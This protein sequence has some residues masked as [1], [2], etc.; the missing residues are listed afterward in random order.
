MV[1]INFNDFRRDFAGAMKPLEE[2]YGV[3]INL[4]RISCSKEGFMSKLFVTKEL[5]AQ[6]PCFSYTVSCVT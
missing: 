5:A 3:A 1:N 4:D 6:A 2:K